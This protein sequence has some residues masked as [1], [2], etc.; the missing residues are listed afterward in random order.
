[1]T[2][3]FGATEGFS[4]VSMA[5]SIVEYGLICGMDVL[6]CVAASV[7]DAALRDLEKQLCIASLYLQIYAIILIGKVFMAPQ[8]FLQEV[9]HHT[10]AT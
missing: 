10:H 2:L 3:E 4:L 8:Q 1:M 9:L 5:L 7:R 6:Q